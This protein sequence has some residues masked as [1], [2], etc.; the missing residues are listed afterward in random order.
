MQKRGP[1]LT[2]DALRLLDLVPS[3]GEF[4]GNT[5]LLRR[6]SLGDRYWA[7][8]KELLNQGILTRGKGRG[9]SVARIAA[10]P[11]RSRVDVNKVEGLVAK[12]A[13]LYEPLKIWLE[14]N[15]GKDIVNGDFFEVQITATPHGRRRSSGKWSRPD[16]TVVQVN[17]YDYLAQSVLEVTTFEVKRFG[18]AEDILSVYETAAHS[19]Q[20]HYSFLVVEVPSKESELPDSITSAVDRFP[21]GLMAMW[22]TKNG[23]QIEERAWDTERL[24]PDPSK[25]DALLRTFFHK[26][27]RRGEYLKLL[28]K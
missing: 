16:L 24:N 21:I 13:E 1:K 17:N 28:G 9:G 23:W 4:V 5:N 14:A 7:V 26:S 12:E 18:D 19:Q 10:G 22:R 6:S 11:R 15:W 8:R 2:K 20:A 25:L 3:S 27:K